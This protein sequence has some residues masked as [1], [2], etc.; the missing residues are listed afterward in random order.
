MLTN[1]KLK[2]PPGSEE[3]YFEKSCMWVE[4]TVTFSDSLLQSVVKEPFECGYTNK[5][6]PAWY[7]SSE[8]PV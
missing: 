7:I 1:M 5:P 6:R 4:S 8:N 2:T 3:I